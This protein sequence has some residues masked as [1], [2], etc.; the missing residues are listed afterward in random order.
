MRLAFS[1]IDGSGKTTLASSLVTRLRADGFK[2]VYSRPRY[3]VC[4]QM[5]DSVGRMYGEVTDFD[6]TPISTVY[7]NGLLIDWFTHYSDFLLSQEDDCIV[8]MDRYLIDVLAQGLH[9]GAD[10]K[11]FD[12][13]NNQLP[14]ADLNYFMDVPVISCVERIAHRNTSPSRKFES[15]EQLT[16]LN[17]IYKKILISSDLHIRRVSGTPDKILQQVLEDIYLGTPGSSPD[18]GIHKALR[19]LAATC[20]RCGL[21]QYL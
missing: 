7:F 18:T 9:I 15:F 4:K 8:V 10:V 13:L 11:H 6:Q 12:W 19:P 1:G 2:A 20:P 3:R 14:A 5:E 21:Y 17:D 16:L